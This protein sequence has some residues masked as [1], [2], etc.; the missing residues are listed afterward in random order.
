MNDT[1]VTEALCAAR[2]Q[3][4]DERFARDKSRLGKA[5]ARL[6]IIASGG[7][8]TL[9]DVEKL[10]HQLSECNTKLT[11]ILETQTKDLED[12]EARLAAIEKKPG[13]YWDKVVAA[14]IGAAASALWAMIRNGG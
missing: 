12:H 3:T 8:S 14:I 9:D 10:M 7:V 11:A 1:P 6:D 5:E 2:R 4:D 13:T